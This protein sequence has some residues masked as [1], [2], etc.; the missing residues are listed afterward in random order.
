MTIKYVF[1]ILSIVVILFIFY[2]QYDFG[3]RWVRFGPD[4]SGLLRENGKENMTGLG[5]CPFQNEQEPPQEPSCT[6]DY[7]NSANLPLREYCVKASFNSAYDGTDVSI[8]TLTQR[9]KDGY[10]FIDL[11]VFSASGDVY[12]GFSPDNAPKTISSKLLLSDALKTINDTAFS[13]ATVFDASLSNVGSYPIFVHIRVYRPPGSN[14]DI[15]ANVAKVITGGKSNPPSYTTNYLR[16][17]DEN[18][19]LTPVQIDGCTVLSSI[20]GNVIFSMDILNIL[21][22]YAPINYQSASTIPP[23]TVESL[24]TFVNILSGGST[25]PAFYRYTDDSLIYRTNTLG[26]GNAAIKGSLQTN[27]KHMYISFP[28]PDD[29]S[30]S[31]TP[32]NQNASGVVQP[33]VKTFIYDRS[34]QFTPLRVYLADT[35]LNAYIN[36]FDTIGTPFASMFYVYRYLNTI[37]ESKTN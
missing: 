18:G 20:M 8:D 23:E 32:K 4:L 17:S 9:I 37:S 14:I 22:I 34:I 35:N 19:K 26:V 28:H 30:T 6:N 36:M 10:R 1:L 13:S 5:G 24:Q 25:F 15:I 33:G 3:Q 31:T 16:K 12:V 7:T 29:V 2:K 11:N 27:V 21:E